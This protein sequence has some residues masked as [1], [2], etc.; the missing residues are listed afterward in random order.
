MRGAGPQNRSN[1]FSWNICYRDVRTITRLTLAVFSKKKVFSKQ[2]PIH[3]E[4]TAL[5]PLASFP[6]SPA[7]SVTCLLP[8]VHSLL[9]GLCIARLC[10]SGPLF[11][12]PHSQSDLPRTQIWSGRLSTCSRI[13]S[14]LSP[15]PIRSLTWLSWHPCFHTQLSRALLHSVC[16][17]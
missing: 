6:V 12:S 10:P 13:Q 16:P 14:P 8:S 7:P 11:P 1:T 5:T 9:L 3:G 15:G 17:F 2:I 4:Q